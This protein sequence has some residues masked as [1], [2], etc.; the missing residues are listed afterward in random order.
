ME[1]GEQSTFRPW[2]DELKLDAA[3][4]HAVAARQ[5]DSPAVLAEDIRR[6]KPLG[7]EARADLARAVAAH[8]GGSTKDKTGFQDLLEALEEAAGQRAAKAL[9]EVNSHYGLAPNPV[10]QPPPPPVPRTL[11]KLNPKGRGKTS[12]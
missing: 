12:S 7:T 11:R 5:S 8:L 3:T 1:M 10:P 9:P 4:A 2:W 6:F